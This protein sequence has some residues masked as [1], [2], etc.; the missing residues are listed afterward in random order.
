MFEH[1][2][3]TYQQ[4]DPPPI[5]TEEYKKVKDD[6]YNYILPLIYS[7]T[8]QEENTSFSDLYYKYNPLE[9]ETEPPGT[10]STINDTYKSD[11][12]K[13]VD[14][15]RQFIGTKYSWGGLTPST[16]FDSAG[17][18]QYAYNQIGIDLPRTAKEISKTGTE[19]ESLDDVQI[20]DL[21]CS[22]SSSGNHVQMV[23][24]I[25]NNQIYT[26]EAKGKKYGVV[27]TPLKDTKKITSIRRVSN[28]NNN[29]IIDY[30]VDKGLTRTQAK[31]IYGNIMQESGG[32]I[33]AISTDGNNSYGLAQWTGKR[34]QK[35]FSMYGTNPNINQQLDF[36]WWELNNTHKDDL[37]SLKKTTTVSQ[38]TKV[39]MDKF[40]RPHKS[41]ANFNRRLKYANSI[42]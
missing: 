19:V 7:D 10:S 27:E 14:T 34:K 21:I 18:I 42:T 15:A 36:L 17:L 20:G 30:F 9:I 40:E 39:F 2:F 38:A 33:K 24:K 22:S 41:Y 37:L 13:A 8:Q 12:Q 5:I 25:D 35:L 16:G 23:S 31:G 11:L 29:F 26:I 32:N 6:Y 28:Q 3:T 1:L 4:T